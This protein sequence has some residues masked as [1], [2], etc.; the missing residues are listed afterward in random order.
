MCVKIL[1]SSKFRRG[2]GNLSNNN[3]NNININGYYLSTFIHYEFENKLTAIRHDD[4]NYN[5]DSD[6]EHNVGISC[7]TNSKNGET[8][9]KT[10]EDDLNNHGRGEEEEEEETE[11]M[12]SLEM[13][14]ERIKHLKDKL[15]EFQSGWV[16]SQIISTRSISCNSISNSSRGDDEV[17][18]MATEARVT[19][20][21]LDGQLSKIETYIRERQRKIQMKGTNRN[22]KESHQQL[23]L[24]QKLQKE[25]KHEKKLRLEEEKKRK[26][27]ENATEKR[28]DK[29]S[30]LICKL[31]NNS[32]T[33]SRNPSIT[34]C[35]CKIASGH[36]LDTRFYCNVCKSGFHETC[37]SIFHANKEALDEETRQIVTKVE[38]EFKETKS[39]YFTGQVVLPFMNV[40]KRVRKT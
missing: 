34:C 3:N 16:K 40:K 38:R 28:R 22:N 5:S 15:T 8:E 36:T 31:I 1:S 19:A 24:I 7:T 6:M 23:I 11:S 27:V 25:L 12:N 33:K 10:P 9:G 29:G 20:H 17:R 21:A 4:D 2:P 37:F 26:A 18:I 32:D 35:F 13:E 30:H 39:C 14:L